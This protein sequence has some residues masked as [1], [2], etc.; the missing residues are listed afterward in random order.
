MQ[1]YHAV[2]SGQPAA[3]TGSASVTAIDGVIHRA[4]EKRPEDRYQSAEAMAQAL[5]AA[6]TLTLTTDTSTVTV[7]PTT[8]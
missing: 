4:L 6:L 2:M 8:G 1:V 3:L 5:R 7:R